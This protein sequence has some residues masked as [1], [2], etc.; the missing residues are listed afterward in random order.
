MS[1]LPIQQPAAFVIFVFVEKELN[2][3]RRSKFER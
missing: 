3:K 1:R 2:T